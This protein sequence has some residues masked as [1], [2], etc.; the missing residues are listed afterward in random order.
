[1]GNRND[2]LGDR[3]KRYENVPKVNLVRRMPVIIRLD[4]KAFHTF[5]RGFAKPFDPVLMQTMNETMKYLCENIQGCVL[6]YTQSDEIT[7]VLVDYQTLTSDAWFD[8]AVEKMCS[9]AASMATM[10]FNNAFRVA[11]DEWFVKECEKDDSTNFWKLNE[12]YAKRKGT[13]LFDARAFNIPKEEVMNCLV[14]RQQDATRNSIQ[15]VGQSQF[16]HKQL[17]GKSCNQI[18]DMLFT[19]RGINWNDYPVSCKRGT[20]CVKRFVDV[21]SDDGTMVQRKKWMLDSNIPIF[22]QQPDYINSLVFVG[23]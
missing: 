2:S 12:T 22:N 6:G 3:M 23:G 17:M 9:I 10:A 5:T 4:G 11:V 13:A 19:E 7:L 18:Q 14:W 8:N 20:C 15:A 21:K 16:S 1:M